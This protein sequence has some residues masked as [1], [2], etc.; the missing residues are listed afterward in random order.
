MLK[1]LCNKEHLLLRTPV[2]LCNFIYSAEAVVQ[3]RS[4]KNVFL[5][6][7]K[8]HRKAPVPSFFFNKVAGPVNFAKFLNKKTF[9]HRTLLVAV[10]EN[11]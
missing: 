4:V 2:S 3:S 7:C 9:L 11:A 5:I 8:I 6:F 1:S 10:S